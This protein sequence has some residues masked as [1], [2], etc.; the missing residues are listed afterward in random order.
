MARAG[1]LEEDAK[2]LLGHG[3]KSGD[4]KK[5]VGDERT[6]A[7]DARIQARV[8]DPNVPEVDKPYDAAHMAADT[9]NAFAAPAGVLPYMGLAAAA[10]AASQNTGSAA[11]LSCMAEDNADKMVAANFL[12]EQ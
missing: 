3:R 2:T 7:E 10:G 8:H 6:L 1:A 5:L 11:R 9:N 12:L 4:E